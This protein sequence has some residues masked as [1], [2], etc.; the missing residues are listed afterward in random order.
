MSNTLFKNCAAVITCDDQKNVYHNV[1][2][3]VVNKLV[4]K[5]AKDIPAAEI[6]DNTTTVDAHGYFIY[7]GLINTHHHF[8]QCFVRNNADLDWTRLS[9]IEWLDRIYPIFSRLDEECFYHA[10]L[11]AMCELI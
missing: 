10:S 6:P 8:F 3:L 11:T 5:I 9:L 7:P 2:L 4:N 1:D